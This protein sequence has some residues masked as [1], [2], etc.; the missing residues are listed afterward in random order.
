MVC[1][2]CQQDQI[3]FA[4]Q[5]LAKVQKTQAA[6]A[7]WRLGRAARDDVFY[8]HNIIARLVTLC[9]LW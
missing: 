9:T 4:Q 2:F 7:L 3:K 5:E 6:E 8:G 1:H